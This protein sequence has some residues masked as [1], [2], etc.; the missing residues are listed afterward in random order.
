[1]ITKQ[2]L[3]NWESEVAT[4]RQRIGALTAELEYNEEGYKKIRKQNKELRDDGKRLVNLFDR[5]RIMCKVLNTGK[6]YYTYDIEQ[7]E[8]NKVIEQHKALVEKHEKGI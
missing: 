4:L 6:E 3:D 1:M 7:S 8:F 2:Q 5:N